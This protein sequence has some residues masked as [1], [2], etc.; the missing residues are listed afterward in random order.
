MLRHLGHSGVQK[1]DD[2]QKTASNESAAERHRSN[3]QLRL[4]T[5]LT[6]EQFAAEIDATQKYQRF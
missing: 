6:Q 3:A 1:S 4:D 2:R 5:G